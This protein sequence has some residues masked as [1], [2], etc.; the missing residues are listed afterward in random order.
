MKVSEA[1]TVQP[2]PI[3]EISP[4]SRTA[5]RG[6]RVREAKPTAVV[7]PVRPTGSATLAS[8]A[9]IRAAGPPFPALSTRIVV[10]GDHVDGV[11]EAERRSGA[12]GS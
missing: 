7:S 4:N 9:A 8:A 12:P 2:T 5:G 1:A 10:L 3:T 6:E 11:G